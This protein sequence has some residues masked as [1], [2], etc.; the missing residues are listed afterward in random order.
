MKVNEIRP[1]AAMAGQAAYEQLD[2][3]WLSARSAGFVAVRCPACDGAVAEFLYFKRGMRQM[4][5]PTCLTQ[6]ASPRP[7]AATLAEFYAQSKNYEYWAKYV[8]PASKEPRREKIFRPRAELTAELARRHGLGGALVEIGSAFGLYLQEVQK[9]GTFGRLIGIEPTPDLAEVGR[10]LGFEI[11][12]SSYE[13]VTFDSQ[14]SMI[15][16]FEVI[17]HLFSPEHF[18]RWCRSALQPGGIVLLTCP[19]IHGFDTLVLGADSGSVDHEHIN[20]FNTESLPLLMGRCGFDVVEVCTPGLLDVE[21]VRESGADLGPVLSRCTDETRAAAFQ[22]F[23]TEN[24]L[25][26]NMR[27]VAR[28]SA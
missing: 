19:N 17:E 21:I 12:H 2:I 26:S 3:D 4:R 11:H 24:R 20:M 7:D 23:L 9:L 10:G 13:A 22:R 1:G 18:L 6:Y 16:A 15:S 5:C 25:S 27:V 8:F 28:R 14:V